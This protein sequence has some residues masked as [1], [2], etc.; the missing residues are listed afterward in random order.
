MIDRRHIS[1]FAIIVGALFVVVGIIYPSAAWFAGV[2]AGLAWM[3]AI[4]GAS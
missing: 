4:G 3:G 2:G 1:A